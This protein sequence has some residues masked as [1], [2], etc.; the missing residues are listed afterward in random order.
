MRRRCSTAHPS[1]PCDV[2]AV[3]VQHPN[4]YGILEPVRERSRRRASGRC[5]SDPGLRPPVAR[6]AR[7]ARRPRCRHRRRGGSGARQPPQL[8]W[9]LPGHPRRAG[10]ATSGSCR[11]ASSARPSTSTATPG[12]VLTLQAREQH[13]RRDKANS[14]ICTNQTLMAIAATVYLGWLGPEGLAELGRQCA[15]KAAFTAQALDGAPGRRRWRSPTRRFFKEFARAP[16]S[17]GGRAFETRWW[18]AGSSPACRCRRRATTCSSW[19]SRNDAHATRS[20]DSCR[21]WGRCWPRERRRPDP[22][23]GP[24][25]RRRARSWNGRCPGAEPSASPRWTCPR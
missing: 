6:G 2:A 11:D 12:Y 5:Q 16:A 25:G 20:T 9:A 14:N 3:V 17:A 18:L 4:V 10:W 24:H 19:P 13:I 22:Y 8:R 7:P 1:R 23:P 21:R 15:S